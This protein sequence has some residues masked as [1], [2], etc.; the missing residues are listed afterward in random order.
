MKSLLLPFII[1]FIVSG[2]ASHTPKLSNPSS[3]L[4]LGNGRIGNGVDDKTVSI[5]FWRVDGVNVRTNFFKQGPASIEIS[6]GKHVITVDLAGRDPDAVATEAI[7]VSAL[8]GQTYKLVG[9]QSNTR[10]HIKMFLITDREPPKFIQTWWDI[11]G[12]RDHTIKQR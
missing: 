9:S 7:I 10:F 4:F 3:C 1:A 8:A 11:K 12:R 5:K 2:C 6:E